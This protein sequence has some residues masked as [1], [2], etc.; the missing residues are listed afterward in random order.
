MK[1]KMEQIKEKKKL[2]ADYLGN[3]KNKNIYQNW[4]DV[5]KTT[6]GKICNLKEFYC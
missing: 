3:N 1:E 2:M 5:A 4:W 6:L